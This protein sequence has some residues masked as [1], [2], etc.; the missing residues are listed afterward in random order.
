M[1][2]A[3][4]FLNMQ[5]AEQTSTEYLPIPD[6]EYTAVVH[7]L[8]VRTPKG[9]HII[10]ITWKL[11]APS[12]EEADGK[13]V[14]QSI[15]LDITES[16]SLDSSKGKNVDLGRLR[17]ALGQNQPGRPWAP[18]MM[19]GQ[20]ALVNVK[21]RVDNDTGRIYHDVKGVAALR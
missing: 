9:N 20:V 10:D 8:D 18:N 12:V 17:E 5:T 2:D 14:R 4:N 13:W 16:G 11:D 3:D 1:F 19:L 21:S 15:F 7:K 6:N